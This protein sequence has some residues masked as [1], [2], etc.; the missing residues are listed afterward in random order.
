MEPYAYRRPQGLLRFSFSQEI[1]P[2]LRLFALFNVIWFAFWLV[3]VSLSAAA[4]TSQQGNTSDAVARNASV[5]FIIICSFTVPTFLI[6]VLAAA[7]VRDR[8]ISMGYGTQGPVLVPAYP[9]GTYAP[10]SMY[11]AEVRRAP[12]A[13]GAWPSGA[14][15]A[16]DTGEWFDRSPLSDRMTDS[17]VLGALLGLPR[18]AAT[19][20]IAT[21]LEREG[22]D[23][24]ASRPAGESAFDLKAAL[25][26]AETIVRV[27]LHRRWR[28]IMADRVRELLGDLEADDQKAWFITSSSFSEDAVELA[29]EAGVELSDGT[30]LAYMLKKHGLVEGMMSRPESHFEIPRR[31]YP[32]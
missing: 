12:P 24:M 23:V 30:D 3:V 5:G 27:T 19:G 9:S 16:R 26:G 8:M 7:R 10:P 2:G 14:W 28:I 11:V 18:E 25:D 6:Q 21:L 4:L 20:T 13:Y 22:F 31:T 17:A 15:R 29:R 1:S 32:W